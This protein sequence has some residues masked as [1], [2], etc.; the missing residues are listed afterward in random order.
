MKML[1]TSCH[2]S[3]MH[4]PNHKF[5]VRILIRRSINFYNSFRK[6]NNQHK[7][8]SSKSSANVHYQPLLNNAK[9]RLIL[10]DL[11][12]SKMLLMGNMDTVLGIN[13]MYKMRPKLN[14]KFYRA[15]ETQLRKKGEIGYLETAKFNSTSKTITIREVHN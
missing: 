10:F 6:H 9:T 12:Q 14:N 7:N 1:L 13:S 15:L 11:T 2:N 3:H 4:R 5:K 8:L